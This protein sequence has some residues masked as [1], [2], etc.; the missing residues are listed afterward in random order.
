MRKRCLLVLAL[1][2][3]V[4]VPLLAGYGSCSAGLLA[5]QSDFPNAKLLVSAT[6]VQKN[7]HNIVIIDARSSGYSSSHISGAINLKYG[8]YLTP[9]SGLK[10]L[11]VRASWVPP[12]LNVPRR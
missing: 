7:L 8:D 9:G 10:D 1:I 12:A 5:S 2:L 3:S 11:A 4:T 6:S